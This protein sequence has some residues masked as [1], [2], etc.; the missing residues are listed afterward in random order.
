MQI[1]STYYLLGSEKKNS[2][3]FLD[4]KPPSFHSE[5]LNCFILIFFIY[6]AY[7]LAFWA[8]FMLELFFYAI[9]LEKKDFFIFRYAGVSRFA[10]WSHVCSA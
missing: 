3:F 6:F 7:E 9:E 10:N 8:G 4:S 2:Y 5:T 1:C